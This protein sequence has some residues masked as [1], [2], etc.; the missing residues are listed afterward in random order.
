MAAALALIDCNHFYASCEQLFDPALQGQPVVV[1]SN[2]DGCIVARSREARQLGIAMGMPYFQVADRLREQQV[3]ELEVY[4]IGQ[5]RIA[6]DLQHER[7]EGARNQ[8]AIEI[9]PRFEVVIGWAGEA[10]RNDR[11][12][13]STDALILSSLVHLGNRCGQQLAAIGQQGIH[14]LQSFQLLRMGGHLV[15][16]LKLHRR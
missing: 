6:T 5:H 14:R 7:A 2:N 1:L 9:N 4:S 11:H 12:A 3:P 10:R 16:Q 13:I 15:L 8:L